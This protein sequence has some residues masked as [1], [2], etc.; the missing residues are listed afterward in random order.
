MTDL[1]TVGLRVES[2][3]VEQGEHRLDAFAV[4]AVRV[5]RAT[6]SLAAGMGRANTATGQMNAEIRRATA[7]V[8]G[9]GS[10]ARDM[11][12]AI[13]A[14]EAAE[15]AAYRAA[16]Q[17]AGGLKS[18]DAALAKTAQAANGTATSFDR[19]YDEAQR[20]FA[21]QYAAQLGV[22]EGALEKT[23]GA[24]N[25]LNAAQ[26]RSGRQMGLTAQESLNL[27]RQVADIGVSLASGQAL[28]MV[29]IQQGAQIG[30]IFQT[31]G[32]RGVGLS[33]VV[34]DLN[35]QLTGLWLRLWPI[36]I[37][38]GLVAGGLALVTN[39]MNKGAESAE[40]MQKRLGLTDAEMKKL[41]NTSVTMGDVIAGTAKYAGEALWD[42]FG[43]TL[44]KIGEFFQ[45]TF[46]W[47]AKI[48]VGGIK[49][50]YGVIVGG[51]KAIV[52]TLKVFP[53][54]M[55][56]LAYTAANAT[57]KAV[58]AMVNRGVAMINML[59]TMANSAM[60]AVGLSLK[61][62]PLKAVDFGELEN[63]F[64]G[65]MKRMG[66]AG[67]A[68]FV[69]G[70]GDVSSGVDGIGAGLM[71]SIF[72]VHE[73]RLARK[74]EELKAKRREA[75]GGANDND[76]L[77]LTDIERGFNSLTDAADRF[78]DQAVK[79]M[80]AAQL[81]AARA[82]EEMSNWQREAGSV[83]DV[84]MDIDNRAG[85]AAAGI[86]GA[87]GK[88][89]R[90]IA[91]VTTL[92][93]RYAAR[94]ADLVERR[95]AEGVTAQEVARIDRET[96]RNRVGYYGDLIGA[97]RGFVDEQSDAYKALQAVEAGYRAWQLAAS[98]Q[99]MIQ[100]MA[101][102]QTKAAA[103]AVAVASHTGAA[104][105]ITATDAATTSTGIAAGAARMFA[106]LGPFAFPVVAAMLAM[107]ASLG[108]GSAGG[109]SGMS[110]SERRQRT[111]GA[112]SVLG[113][114]Q[115]QS[116]SIANA[117]Q[118]VASNS[119][120]ELEY[121]ND[122]LKA[123]RSIDNQIG[124]VAAALARSFGA[125][126]MLDT[127]KLN[128]GTSTDGPGALQRL[129]LPI[130][131]LLPGLF[132]STTTRK[133]QDQGVQFDPA[134]LDAIASGG[135]AGEAYQ[136]ILQTTKKKAFGLTYS[137]STKKKT[138][139]SPLD[140]D[141]LRQSE[142]LIGSLRDGVLAAAG[143]LGVEGAAATLAAFTVNLGKLSFKDM[144]GD[145]IQS[146]LEGI[147]GKLADDLAA[148]AVPAILTLQ[149]VG[150]GAFETLARVARQYQVVDYALASVGKTFGAVGVSSL[151]AR[152]RLVDLFGGL[153][154]LTEQ[155]GFYAENF[156]SEAERLA[157]VQSAVT[158]EL[159]RLG[160]SGLKTRDQFKTLAQ[161]LDVSTE[162]G[163]TMYAAL[164]ALAPAF[165]RI[166]EESQAVA[167]A[168]SALSSAYERERDEISAT[169]DMH[170]D[171]AASLGEYR[172][173]L[174]SGPAAALS[175]EAAY[176][177]AQAEFARVAGF[178]AG[179][180]ASA[181][182]KLQTVSDAYLQASKGYY[183]S[184]AG[185]F[186][187]LAA[188][189]DAVTAAEGIAGAQADVATQQLDQL[190][191]LVS[192]F[193]DLNESVLS[194]ADAITALQAAQG[195]PS[196]AAAAPASAAAPTNDNSELVAKLEALEARMAEV[197]DR[198]DAANEQRGAG[199]MMTVAKLDEQTDLQSR[200][201]RESQVA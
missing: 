80:L 43:P 10:A 70:L 125:G 152:E 185:Y 187:D 180:D 116:E 56:D 100:T 109:V 167:D 60:G 71:A 184:S 98:I 200:Q 11:A 5:D 76:D 156:L 99:A 15:M 111:Q 171:L 127:S 53:A 14:A 139:T 77:G 190:R 117:L 93:T 115:A 176:Q 177:A 79:A 25:A 66:Q 173:S 9:A 59:I 197:V 58:E 102:A 19:I 30:D 168:R 164:M 199:I 29:A 82:R 193:I 103:D 54:A 89:G 128:L 78:A 68:G 69:E 2:R 72:G 124:A 97:A 188:V 44:T 172:Q 3:E 178:A 201:L 163:A 120:A 122:M 174:Y 198:L 26:L 63:R 39:Q 149:K 85:D 32:A 150:E 192:G 146:A 140:D 46:D 165:A 50:Q 132:G 23:T 94:Q 138:Y 121:S 64:A 21:T 112:G 141:F 129:F 186:A 123:L 154:N 18:A 16:L 96:A 108:A 162:A 61:I 49:L 12:N 181:L 13:R 131:N 7:A 105:V 17:L 155:V 92:M 27:S 20:N 83:A 4:A 28:W 31:A 114:S 41:G 1:A 182:G 48:V 62:D 161:G 151:A 137:E 45:W 52:E 110:V 159:A 8:D 81:A 34:K 153:D 126:G 101:E 133:L 75:K 74:A 160:L 106:A 166:T 157:P 51:Y 104:A 91:D 57:I 73:D 136:Q 148:S 175:P 55:G 67:V 147:F 65:S 134:T 169:V 86:A 113:D 118:I 24:Q 87:F 130:S 179:G 191:L 195:A 88:V 142:L 145:E 144:T 196:A 107:M 47:I 183:A 95:K 90:A 135:L 158:A 42:A 35:K 170:R 36:A 84:L 189:R 40:A 6:D 119:Y 33:G 38:A 37:V 194:V 22:V 143:I